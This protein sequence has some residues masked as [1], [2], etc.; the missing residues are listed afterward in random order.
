MGRVGAADLRLGRGRRGLRRVPRGRGGDA[1]AG[2]M[3]LRR[4]V[5]VVRVI[6]HVGLDGRKD[7]RSSVRP[8]MVGR[9]GEAGNDPNRLVVLLHCLHAR[10]PSADS[11]RRR[12]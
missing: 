3:M 2:M 9:R 5:E 4:A 8:G 10:P 11:T 6:V 1:P 7:H 12:W